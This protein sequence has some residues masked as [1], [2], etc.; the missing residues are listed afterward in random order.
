MER[1]KDGK[2]NRQITKGN[3]IKMQLKE[4]KG[5]KLTLKNW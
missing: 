3:S 4:K 1:Q 5:I 2:T